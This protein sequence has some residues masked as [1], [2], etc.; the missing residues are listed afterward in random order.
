MEYFT[1][2]SLRINF[3]NNS[4]DSI[5]KYASIPESNAL[6]LFFGLP[7]LQFTNSRYS[8]I[9]HILTLITLSPPTKAENLSTKKNPDICPCITEHLNQFS[10]FFRTRSGWPEALLNVATSL[11]MLLQVVGRSLRL[12]LEGGSLNVLFLWLKYSTF[13]K[14][15]VSG[16]FL[17]RRVL[18]LCINLIQKL[19]PKLAFIYRLIL[20]KHLR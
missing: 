5:S 18:A 9:W 13:L 11:C 10:Y 1:H 19:G 14:C 6:P 2:C 8:K 4:K 16:F 3:E 17:L 12:L 7:R 20:I 15:Q